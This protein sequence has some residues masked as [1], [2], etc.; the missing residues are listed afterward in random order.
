MQALPRPLAEA[1]AAVRSL[2]TSRIREV[3]N[4][5]MAA[6]DVLAFWFGEPDEVTPQF[7][8]DAGA[9]SLARGETF[10]TQNLGIP[11]LRRA[12]ARYASG[13]H[14]PVAEA[15][16]A[17]TA[18][19]MSALMLAVEALV[20]PGDRVVVVTPLWPN[21]VEI[22]KILSAEVA[23]VPLAFADSA[24]T[25]DLDRLLDA[26]TPDTRLLMINSPNN[27]TGWTI[28]REQQQAILDRC[29]RHGTWLVA[30]DVYE[31]LYFRDDA[32]SAPS[33][34]DLADP[35]ER[36]VSTN[37][38]SKS[39]LMTGWRLGWLIAPEA[40]MPDVGKLIEYNTSCSPAFVQHAGVAAITHGEATVAHTR[41]RFRRARDFLVGELARLPGIEVAAPAG[42]MYAFFRVEGLAD[43]LDFCKRLVREAR[44]GLAPGSA[45]GPEGEGFVRWCFAS[46]EARLADGVARLAGYLARHR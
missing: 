12:I 17:V 33:F 16:V 7:I 42:A 1:R 25:L 10:Y 34:L 40:L 21:L 37:S 19:G 35:D 22:P 2:A 45:F 15:S 27:P 14:R 5:G 38:F 11:S 20:A 28:T 36:V 3:A 30:D 9:A 24:W 32:Q 23:C 46:D 13:L 8:R 29:R 43:S 26:L 31:R 44:L 39:W 6:G 18:S 4:E 41:A